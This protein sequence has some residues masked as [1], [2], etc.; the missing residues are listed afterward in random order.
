[1]IDEKGI[2]TVIHKE[3]L[4]KM[5]VEDRKAVVDELSVLKDQLKRSEDVNKTESRPDVLQNVA[6]IKKRV[7]Q[8]E[9]S[10]NK[11]DDLIPKGAAQNP[12]KKRA[13]E[14]EALIK[15]D[16]PSERQQKIRSIDDASGFEKA[17]EQTMHHERKYGKMIEEWQEIMRRLEPEDPGACS[18]QR[19][20]S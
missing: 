14:L 19:L 1:M 12:L 3:G 5:A 13:E 10:L 2:V 8:L 16:M 4:R 7:R 17:V 9:E 18:V 11:D 15:K 6:N 20:M